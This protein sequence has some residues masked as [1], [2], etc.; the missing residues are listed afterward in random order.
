MCCTG[1]SLSCSTTQLPRLPKSRRRQSLYLSVRAN[2]YTSS[3]RALCTG[4][5]GVS[6]ISD[7][8]LY[9]KDS[10]IHR[11]IAN[12][13]LQGGGTIH[14][15]CASSSSSNYLAQ[16]LQNA[17]AAEE[18]LFM[19]AHSPTRIWPV[20]WILK[21]GF[22]LLLNL[23]RS[24]HKLYRLLCMANKGPN[25][26]GSQYFITLKDC[27]HLNGMLYAVLCETCL[28]S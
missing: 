18:S 16:I 3:F 20:R 5:K 27:P 15:N 24:H 14:H 12:F 4:E 1:S 19:E 22:S 2:L 6:P 11:A 8:P 7:R 17:M 23:G 28:K 21:G 10:I 9:Y 25:T 13:M 26:N